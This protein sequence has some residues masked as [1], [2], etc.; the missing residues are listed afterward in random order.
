VQKPAKTRFLRLKSW[1]N[2]G[3]IVA[4]FSARVLLSIYAGSV[5]PA[6]S[7]DSAHVVWTKVGRR[8]C[9]AFLLPLLVHCSRWLH[10]CIDNDVKR[11][12]KRPLIRT[13]S[14]LFQV[15]LSLFTLFSLNSCQKASKNLIF[16]PHLPASYGPIW[17]LICER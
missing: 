12:R 17:R 10:T 13:S 2:R 1:Q 4:W 5:L 8:D 9:F 15:R 7:Q 11:K 16:C 3:K 6:D 14:G